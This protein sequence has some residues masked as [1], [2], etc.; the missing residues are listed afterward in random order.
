MSVSPIAF[1]PAALFFT[2]F[3]VSFLRDRRKLRNG[4]YLFLALA[5][6]AVAMLLVVGTVSEDTARVLL[7]I[8][9]LLIPV[10][11]LAF[12]VFL[13]ASGVTM[14]RREG[15]RPANLVSLLAGIGIVAYVP[16]ELLVALIDW[17]PLTVTATAITGVLFY[18][19]FLFVC[20]LLY[21]VVY[22]RIRSR[23]PVDYIVV[24][25]AGLLDGRRVPP[26]LASRL[27]R[28]REVFD[29]Q[30]ARGADPILVT[31]GGQ[32]PDEEVPEAHAMRDHLVSH[33]VPSDRV[34]VEDRSTTTWENLM[35]SAEL[36]RARTS[37]YG[38]VVVTNNFHVLRAALLARKAKLDGQVVGAPTA[39]YFWSS[40]VVREFIAVLVA[41]RVFNGVLCGVIV[42]SRVLSAL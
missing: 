4:V 8:G 3:L 17:K 33:G 27:G 10:S 13:I 28:G 32:G 36:M 21:S 24:L 22:G 5:S 19:S 20:F 11:V 42:L 39:W 31:S 37:D 40:A 1:V 15:R 35:F 38:C 9:V 16:A 18:V 34:M 2:A 30:R 41:H 7:M 29:E 6:L 25:G 26:L 12:G 14:L 23:R